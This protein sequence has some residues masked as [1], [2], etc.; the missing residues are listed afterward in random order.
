MHELIAALTR[1]ALLLQDAIHGARRAEVLAFVKQ[2][3]LHGG[4][5]AVL[6]AL[7]ME[8]LQ[9]RLALGLAE[10]AS[11][12][13]LLPWQRRLGRRRYRWTQDRPLPIERSTGHSQEIAG[14][15]D[16]NGGGQMGDGVHQ[17]FSSGSTFGRGHPNR[18]PTFFC[19]SMTM[20]ALRNSSVRRWFSRR[21][22]WLSSS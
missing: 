3:G 21:S 12:S 5:G 18:S 14:G 4:R 13:C 15:H 17:G 16:A 20:A 22:F 1:F 6:E 9:N 11:G 7:F 19:T 2:G 10:G 8:D